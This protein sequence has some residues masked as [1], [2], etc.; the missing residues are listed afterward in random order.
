[1]TH[2]GFSWDAKTRKFDYESYFEKFKQCIQKAATLYFP[3]YDL[4]WIIRC[5]ASEH[6]VGAILFQ[7]LT[8]PDGFVDHQPIAFSSKR[9]SGP[10]QKWDAYK[11][12]AYAIYHSVHSFSWYL[13]GKDF[14][15][16]TDHRNLQW[17]ETSQSPI[18]CRWSALL[19]SFNFKIRHIPGRENKVA[20][21]ISRPALNVLHSCLVLCREC[22]PPRLRD[23]PGSATAMVTWP[24]RSPSRP[25]PLP[26]NKVWNLCCRKYTAGV[27]CIMGPPLPG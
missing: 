25:Q 2:D 21:W 20:D 22:T 15:V 13:R 1:M 5:D 7:V 24:V 18:V 4:P 27:V 23:L 9:F 17:I 10:A 12:E 11:R 19:Q 26:A 16:E 14:L 6:A 3:R 8:N